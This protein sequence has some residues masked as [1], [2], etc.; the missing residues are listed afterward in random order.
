ML[1]PFASSNIVGAT[2]YGLYP[3]HDALQVPTLLRVVAA[4]AHHWLTANT[5]ATT[6]NIVGPT[7]LAVV[8][9]VCV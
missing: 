8:A 9:S 2:S 3:F 1:D 6:P 7:M 4:V 5:D